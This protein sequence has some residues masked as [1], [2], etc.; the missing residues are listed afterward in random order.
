MECTLRS[1]YNPGIY[2]NSITAIKIPV[3]VI[4]TKKDKY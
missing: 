2:E 3:N 4:I 1:F